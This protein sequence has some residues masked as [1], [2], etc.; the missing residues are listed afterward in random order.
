M[1]SWKA[2]SL[3][4][5]R[6]WLGEE[7]HTASQR[8][9]VIGAQAQLWTEYIKEGSKVE[10]MLYP[11][12]CAVSEVCWSD[13][14]AK[15]F[16][17]FVARLAEH[18]KRLDQL[19]VN[20]RPYVYEAGALLGNWKSGGVSS[21]FR[22]QTW[23]V[24]NKLVTGKGD[25]KL[26]FQYTSGG[27]RLDIQWVEILVNGQVVARSEQYG[28]TGAFDKDNAYK[29]SLPDVPAGAKIELRANV[30][31]DGGSDSNGDITLTKV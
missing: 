25:Y 15:S 6:S 8:Q 10:Y 14:K 5:Q 27:Q 26:V 4:A 22:V 28:V 31:A 16:A 19:K 9:H 17:G 20:Y 2:D 23:A 13:T 11:R 1:K 24:P 29:L 30:K 3:L 12:L 18:A 7:L 21:S